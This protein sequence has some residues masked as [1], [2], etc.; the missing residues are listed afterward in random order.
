MTTCSNR[1]FGAQIILCIALIASTGN[2]ILAQ[3][4]TDKDT[5]AAVRGKIDALLGGFEY[6]PSPDEWRSLGSAA[7]AVLAAIASDQNALPTRRARSLG[8]LASFDGIDRALFETLAKSEQEPLIVRISAVHGLGQLLPESSR[9]AALQPLLKSE[10]PQL[11]GVVAEVL[12]QSRTGCEE[13]RAQARLETE[14]WRSRFARGCVAPGATAGKMATSPANLSTGTTGHASAAAAVSGGPKQYIIPLGSVSLSPN[15]S[16][17][18]ITVN[19]P[20]SA[21]SFE[22]VGVAAD[23]TVFVQVSKIVDPSGV[24]IYDITS[25]TDIL[26]YGGARRGSFS[27][28]LPNTPTLA[29]APGMWTFYLQSSLV[30][31]TVDVQVIYKTS[32]TSPG[33]GT[34]DANLF[35]VG[36]PNLSAKSAPTDPNFQTILSTVRSLYSQVGVTLGNLTYIDITGADAARFTVLDGFDL[37]SL[38]QLSNHP[39]A[40]KEAVNIFLVYEICYPGCGGVGGIDGS[41]PAT[42]IRGTGES[43]LVVQMADF[44]NGLETLGIVFAHEMGHWL[45]LFHTTEVSGLQFDP[46]PDTPECTRVPY[47]TDNNRIVT[48]QECINL[49]ATNV[50]FWT[51]GNVPNT[52]LTPDQGFVMLRNPVQNADF[53]AVQ[54]QPA[55]VIRVPEDF[56]TIQLAVNAANVGDTIR[57]GAGRWCGALISTPK[58]NLVGKGATIMGCPPGPSGTGPVGDQFK[59][60]FYLSDIGFGFGALGTSIRGFVFDGTGFFDTNPS[61]LATGILSFVGANI[62][63]NTFLG[64]GYPV[65]L[66]GGDGSQV[67]NNVFD[68]FTVLPSNGFGGAAII[69]LGGLP[70][71]FPGTFAASNVIQ[72]NT[73]TSKVPPGDF[74]AFSWISEVD[75]PLVGIVLSGQ[76]GA[77]VSNNKSFIISN[78]NGDAGAGILATDAV[79]GLTDIN[80]V[81]TNNNG[82][83]SQYS[84]IITDDLSGGTGNTVGA[85]IKGNVGVNL[86]DG[87]T[88]NARKHSPVLH[89]DPTTGV[90]TQQ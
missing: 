71:Q 89:C 10:H 36:L 35:F 1:S 43:G 88:F 90:C 3:D 68:G 7:P 34:I 55:P 32:T 24:V 46:L 75:V 15:V 31:T 6:V 82:K 73:I 79:T 33:A 72:Y 83:K 44:P 17:G 51:G 81:I 84:L 87:T 62:D 60:G 86:I 37:A 65:Y 48:V 40:R 47:D 22:I 27:V 58:L 85:T 38:L 4:Q 18:P 78:A 8:G 19:L 2:P 26:K 39:Q 61:A 56:P 76:D 50:M 13:V 45:G 20:A 66:S 30:D 14:A 25:P 12:A 29:F 16:S 59:I 42:P 64:G 67:T 23:P 80:S 74:S 28:L 53:A 63:S 41:I 5:S 77:I 11:R 52:V 54:I 49:D 9:L 70:P 21:I 69:D 57:V